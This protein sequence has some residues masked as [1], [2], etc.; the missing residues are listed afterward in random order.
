MLQQIQKE[1]VT[2]FDII[3]NVNFETLKFNQASRVVILDNQ[4]TKRIAHRDLKHEKVML[5]RGK[6]EL[7]SK[8]QILIKTKSKNG[9]QLT[10]VPLQQL[11]VPAELSQ[12][13]KQIKSSFQISEESFINRSENVK[14]EMLE[15]EACQY[16]KILKN[17]KYLIKNTKIVNFLAINFIQK[18]V[19]RNSFSR[20]AT[21]EY[22][23]LNH[24]LFQGIQQDKLLSFK[25]H[26]KVLSVILAENSS[27]QTYNMEE[28]ENQ[29]LNFVEQ[30]NIKSNDLFIDHQIWYQQKEKIGTI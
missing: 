2:I 3:Q 26:K 29:N 9:Q 14:S 13:Y 23:I 21:N 19:E 15:E 8:R 18:I 6:I 28:K 7:Q 22:M 17:E 4:Y 10:L 1:K 12:K 25:N 30:F 24:I 11:K 5:C 27:T 20:Q 16:I